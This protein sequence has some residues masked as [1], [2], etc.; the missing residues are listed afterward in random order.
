MPDGIR[1]QKQARSIQ[2]YGE[3]RYASTLGCVET[4]LVPE[5]IRGQRQGKEKLSTPRPF[6]PPLPRPASL[7]PL[8]K[9]PS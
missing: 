9:G 4:V 1:N 6:P 5:E 8:P 7:S 3:Q 2:F